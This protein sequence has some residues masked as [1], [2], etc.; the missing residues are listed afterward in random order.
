MPHLV[1]MGVMLPN[2]KRSS[3]TCSGHNRET[4]GEGVI[5]VKPLQVCTSVPFQGR[6]KETVA[7]D[8]L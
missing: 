4:P 8:M 3:S 7:E 5:F 1:C 2:T 6:V